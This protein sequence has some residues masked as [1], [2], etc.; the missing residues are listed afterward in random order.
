MTIKEHINSYFEKSKK[1]FQ[2]QYGSKDLNRISIELLNS[3]GFVEFTYSLK[4]KLFPTSEQ[5]VKVITQCDFISSST[6]FIGK[7]S[8]FDIEKKLD[9]FHIAFLIILEK[10]T[11]DMLPI[12]EN[13]MPAID[14]IDENKAKWLNNESGWSA[15]QKLI[16]RVSE[17]YDELEKEF[18]TL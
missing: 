18:N 15:T 6:N 5:I 13:I 12:Q 1:Y 8:A 17:M 4:N 10:W 11:N 3:K 16:N 9:Y 14:N 7:P 2:E